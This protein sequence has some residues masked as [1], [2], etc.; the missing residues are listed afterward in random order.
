MIVKINGK[1][2]GEKMKIM[3]MKLAFCH[4]CTFGP[5]TPE[6]YETIIY[7]AL[8]GDQSAFMRAD[9]IISSWKIIDKITKNK[10]KIF[11]YEKGSFGPKEAEKLIFSTKRN[12]FNKIENVVQGN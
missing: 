8:I 10:P 6:A 12:W 7:D 1:Q 9:E 2:P 11:K 4:Q 3:P 5:N